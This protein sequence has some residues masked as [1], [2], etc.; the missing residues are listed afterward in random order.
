MPK[1]LIMAAGGILERSGEIL[2]V[3]RPKGKLDRG[4]TPL[5]AALREVHEETGYRAKALGFAG[6]FGYEVKGAPKVVLYWKMKP[7]KQGPILDP[8]EVCELRW[9]TVRA[10]MRLMTYEMERDLVKRMFTA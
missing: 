4:E 5:Q 6:A 9:V 7:L 10:A 8:D 3:Q 1:K 2:L